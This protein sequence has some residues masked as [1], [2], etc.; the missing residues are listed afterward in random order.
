MTL[1][2]SAIPLISTRPNLLRAAQ[3]AIRA[4]RLTQAHGL[5]LAATVLEPKNVEAWLLLGWTTREPASAVACFQRALSLEPGNVIIQDSLSWAT[6]QVPKPETL[7]VEPT[8]I[9]VPAAKVS[10]ARLDGARTS[11]ELPATKGDPDSLAP[12]HAADDVIGCRPEQSAPSRPVLQACALEEQTT[13]AV[14]DTAFGQATDRLAPALQTV[15][16][17]LHQARFNWNLAFLVTCLFALAWA[18]L[19]TTHQ[20]PQTG[21]LLYTVL[22]AA[23]LAYA[24][25]APRGPLQRLPLALV[26]APLIRLLSVSLPL[27]RFPFVYWYLVIGT[28]LFLAGFV[29]VRVAGLSRVKIGLTV[30]TWRPQVW[31][32]LSGIGIGCLEYLILRPTPLIAAPTLEQLWLPALILLVFTGFLEEFLFRGLMQRAA[33][34]SL[35]Q[36]GIVYVAVL[37]A[38]LHVGYHSALDVA[39]VLGVGLYFGGV[40]ARTG[41][42][43]GVTIAHGLANIGLFLIFPF[44][45]G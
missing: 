19:V 21:L 45:F 33:T 24:V 14:A 22:L 41:S 20:S 12:S 43:V 16:A 35:G 25:F 18:E 2:A 44:M 10:E 4:G 28:P 8:Q 38:A 11:V 31:V 23:L 9:K 26:V 15:G 3:A 7:A 39:F 13:R 29:A 36:A 1:N 40:V 32:S 30:P 6:A 37:F 42:I 34:E 17:S 27:S 5:L